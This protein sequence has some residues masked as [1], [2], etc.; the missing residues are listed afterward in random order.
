ML[1]YRISINELFLKTGISANEIKGY[2]AG[3]RTIPT[4]VVDRIKQIGEENV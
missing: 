1:K 3:R 4:Y 2:L